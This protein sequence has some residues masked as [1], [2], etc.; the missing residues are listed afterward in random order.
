VCGRSPAPK[1]RDIGEDARLHSCVR[2]AHDKVI[3][4][5]VDIHEMLMFEVSRIYSHQQECALRK[6][7]CVCLFLDT[8]CPKFLPCSLL[9][10]RC[11][12][13]ACVG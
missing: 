11:E 4:E 7:S 2:F 9:H 12:D 13:E 1:V 5:M 10:V 6:H 8:N 3:E